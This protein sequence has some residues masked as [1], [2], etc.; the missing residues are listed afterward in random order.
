MT[1]RHGV[2]I[3]P[4]MAAALPSRFAF[5]ASVAQL[6]RIVQRLTMAEPDDPAAAAVGFESHAAVVHEIRLGDRRVAGVLRQ[7]ER[8]RRAGPLARL[9]RRRSSFF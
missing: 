4:V 9:D 7:L 2:V 3:V 8:Q 6:E 5:L 1:T